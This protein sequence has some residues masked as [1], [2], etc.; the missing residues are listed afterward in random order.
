MATDQAMLEKVD[1]GRVDAESDSRLNDYFVDTGIL[2]RI[3]GGMRQFIIGRKGSGKTALFQ[4]TQ[5]HLSNVVPI[6]FSDYAWEQHKAIRELG[7]PAESAY[8]ASWMFTFLM[9]SCNFWRTCGDKD[10]A[11]AAQAT[12]EQIFG[13]ED[14]GVLGALFDKFK[15]VRKLELPNAGDLGGLGG[16][17]LDEISEGATLA[18]AAN[19]WTTKLLELAAVAYP[20]MP[21][22][23]IVDRLDDG[24]DASVEVRDMLAGAIKAARDINLKFGQAGSARPVVLFLRSDIYATLAFNDKNKI[25]GDIEYLDWTND[26]LLEVVR[27]RIA[28]S[29]DVPEDRAWDTVFSPEQMRQRAFISSYMLKRTMQRPRDI[30]AFCGFCR[31]A[32]IQAKGTRIETT[33]IYEGERAYSRHVFDELVDEMHK[34]I[35]DHKS[36]FKSLKALGYRRFKFAAWLEAERRFNA[37][38]TAEEAEIRLKTLFDFG[39]IGVPKVGGKGGG[40]TFEFSYQDR[41][42]DAQFDADLVVHLALTKQ[43]SLRDA[44]ADAPDDIE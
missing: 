10:V 38:M 21:T 11:K 14:V 26:E 32:A 33:D 5:A 35:V 19:L 44:T 1:F 31:D 43:L 13:K 15:R 16:F 29:L 42:L 24:W 3:S 9:A 40:S 7:M 6:E 37:A 39:V 28:K 8:T 23:V 17:E 25:S 34:Q 36:L 27:Q 12:Y 41:Y 18:R 4:Q 2:R 20:K 30:I 22:T